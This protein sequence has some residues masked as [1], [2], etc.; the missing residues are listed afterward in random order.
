[1]GPAK[2]GTHVYISSAENRI[3]D[4]VSGKAVST[5]IYLK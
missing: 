1:L 5:H 3:D 4:I 2:M